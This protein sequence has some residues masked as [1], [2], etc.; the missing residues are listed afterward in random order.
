M[1]DPQEMLYQCIGY[2][3]ADPDT[4]CCLGCGRPS[5]ATIPYGDGETLARYDLSPGESIT[6]DNRF[7]AD[8][9]AQ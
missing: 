9:L 8:P 2:C 4:G 1:N 3:Q 5:L 7:P 6:A